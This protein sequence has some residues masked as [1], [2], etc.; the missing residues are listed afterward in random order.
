MLHRLTRWP[1]TWASSWRLS[2]ASV[3]AAELAAAACPVWLPSPPP[4]PLLLSLKKPRPQ[5]RTRTCCLGSGSS[6]PASSAAIAA[7]MLSK[8]SCGLLLPGPTPGKLALAEL[9]LPVLSA[10]SAI[11]NAS[12]GADRTLKSRLGS[13]VCIGR[14]FW[15]CS[16]CPLQDG[17]AEVPM[18]R[19]ACD[20]PLADRLWQGCQLLVHL[21]QR[22]RRLQ[23]D[24]GAEARPR[25]RRADVSHGRQIPAACRHIGVDVKVVVLQQERPPLESCGLEVRVADGDLLAGLDWP[26]RPVAIR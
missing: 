17:S 15:Q 22:P 25:A 8:V 2:A 7:S 10:A 24:A 4:W 1:S 14:A 23:R 5:H 11:M 26:H 19:L 12:A 6:S 16:F 13:T 20:P 18:Q 9:P 3:A 21:I